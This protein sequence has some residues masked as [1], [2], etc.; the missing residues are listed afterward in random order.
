M[1]DDDAVERLILERAVIDSDEGTSARWYS[2]DGI[3]TRTFLAR[4][5]RLAKARLLLGAP[6][7][8]DSGEPFFD[9]FGITPLGRGRLEEIRFMYPILLAKPV[10]RPHLS[11][12]RILDLILFT[13]G[14]LSGWGA[15]RFF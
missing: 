9:F 2:Q 5:D 10:R 15:A 7:L 3:E 13:S 1:M 11:K 8:A 14:A 6:N 4:A 12:R